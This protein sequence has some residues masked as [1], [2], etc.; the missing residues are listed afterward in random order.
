MVWLMGLAALGLMVSPV[1][2]QGHPSQAR[3]G[4]AVPQSPRAV[5]M[6]S[7]SPRGR[8]GSQPFFGRRFDRFEDRFERRFGFARFDR[9]EDRFE[10]RVGFDR[11]LRTPFGFDPFL[12]TRFGFAPSIGGPFGSTSFFVP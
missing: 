4:T 7:F 6:R 1:H 5:S 3:Q 10:G 8:F 2:G 9:F 12:G 11:F